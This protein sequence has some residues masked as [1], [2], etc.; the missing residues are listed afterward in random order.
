MK[1]LFVKYIKKI[2][3]KYMNKKEINTKLLEALINFDFFI[4][5]SP[6]FSK[7]SARQ[8]DKNIIVKGTKG[9]KNYYTINPLEIIKSLKRIIRLL[10]FSQQQ[11]KFVLKLN[12][13]ENSYNQELFSLIMNYKNILSS[14]IIL[15]QIY[16]FD[17][18]KQAGACA[19]FGV[20][21]NQKNYRRIFEDNKH[22]ILEF[23]SQITKNN[24]GT[25]KLF[26]NSDDW[27]KI[28]FLSLLIKN[29]FKLN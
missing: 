8:F 2:N 5:E 10:Q 18:K 11:R 17:L 19:F 29:T 6:E 28:I 13:N 24:Y 9:L 1:K 14:N 27:K 20:T 4:F 3:K 22:L 25:Y 16:A 12:F 26:L 23:N 15:E 7:V 21:Q